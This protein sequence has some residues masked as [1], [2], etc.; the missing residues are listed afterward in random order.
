[1]IAYGTYK[2]L[3]IRDLLNPKK[4]KI[5]TNQIVN[6]ITCVKFSHNGNYI[7]YGDEKGGVRVIG[8]SDA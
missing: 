4:S 6:N 5:Y 7:A 8:W 3:V 1:M 2:N